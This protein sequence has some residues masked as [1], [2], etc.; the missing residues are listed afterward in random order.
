MKPDAWDTDSAF[1]GKVLTKEER[2]FEQHRVPWIYS[3]S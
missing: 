2:F 1:N 3:S